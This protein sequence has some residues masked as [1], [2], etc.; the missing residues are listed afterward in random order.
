MIRV[1][2]VIHHNIIPAT[3]KSFRAAAIR[4]LYTLQVSVFVIPRD[5]CR[6]LNSPMERERNMRKIRGTFHSSSGAVRS[7]GM[8]IEMGT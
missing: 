2:S 5:P 3:T 4:P 7:K 1:G 8:V 6:S